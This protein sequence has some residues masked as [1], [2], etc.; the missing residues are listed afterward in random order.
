MIITRKLKLYPPN[1]NKEKLLIRTAELQTACVN[2]WIEKIKEIEST[3]IKELQKRF[4][5]EA[6]GKFKLGATMT[7]LAEY[8]AIRLVRTS[9][10]KRRDAPSLKS[11]IMSVSNLKID[12]NNLGISF[13]EG[14]FWIPFKSQTIPEGRFK[15]S[16]IKKIN[17]NWYCFLSVEVKEPKVKK[18]KRTMGVDLGLAKIAVIADSNGKNTKFFR[19]EQ[20]R[21]KRSYYYQ[22]RKKLQPKIKQGNVYKLL[23]KLSKKESNWMTDTNHKISREIVN[24]ATKNKRTIAIENL[25]GIRERIKATRKVRRMLHS[26]SFNQLASFI[27]Y[28]ARLAG[29]HCV[30]VDPRETSRK[31]PKCGYIS[32][33]NRKSQERFKCKHCGYES[34][35]DR[36]GAMNIAQRATE[37]LAS[38]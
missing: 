2:Y 22:L 28:K 7:Q 19:G 18:Y 3:S 14:Y 27:E 4:Y 25:A 12:K 13:G 26:W 17:N 5:Y 6:R 23:K 8:T 29:L 9:K 16:K 31:C 34:N 21:A 10:K 32:R 35:A 36:I 20:L 30:S 11:Q 15:E 24:I 37:L 33:S 38:R 1:K